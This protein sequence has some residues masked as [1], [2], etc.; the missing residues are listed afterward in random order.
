MANLVELRGRL[1][2]VRSKA[3]EAFEQA[4]PEMNMS[5]ITSIEGDSAAKAAQLK[6]WNDEMTDISKEIDDHQALEGM[7]ART[8]ALGELERPPLPGTNGKS[9]RR[10]PP[11]SIGDL[12]VESD[13]RTLKNHVASFPEIEVKTLFETGGGSIAYTDATAGWFP[14]DFRSP[15]FVETAVGRQLLRVVDLIPTTT[16]TAAAITYVQEDTFT[17]QAAEVTEGSAKP[18]AALSTTT[19]T[20]PVRK[21]AVWIPVTEEQLA[22]V[23][24]VRGYLNNRLGWM[25]RQRLDAQVLK[26]DGTAP[27]LSGIQ[28][29][30]DI[31]TQA[32]GADPTPDAIYKA[33]TK[34]RV[35]D[36]SE[37]NGVVLHPNDWQDIRL[38]R[39]SDGIYIW[40]SPAD[41][42]PERV[43]GLPIAITTAET[44]GTGLVGDFNQAE[45]AMRQ[46]VDIRV[47][48][49]H[50]DYFVSNILVVLAELRAA[51]LVYRPAAFCTVTGI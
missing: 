26:G 49:S 34:I 47:T 21:I 46:G 18:E 41:Q 36:F 10:E 13:A 14:M 50:D 31:Q 2:A 28:D 11:K 45:L 23:P 7:K 42:G 3:A 33:I 4:G 15:R 48:D 1:E 17:N 9:E 20:E 30:T 6:A 40:G 44:E 43:W 19:V 22:D 16:T 27:N 8:D 24:Q 35:N 5:K 12:F 29:R 37:P 39:T 38:L 32:K 25:V 51:L